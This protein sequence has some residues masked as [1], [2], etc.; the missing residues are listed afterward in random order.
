MSETMS[1][2]LVKTSILPTDVIS[3]VWFN[4]AEPKD[5]GSLRSELDKYS[6]RILRE[7]PNKPVG[8]FTGN[9]IISKM[10]AC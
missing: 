5:P 7:Q 1:W 3:S 10:V 4:E 8:N 2:S 9:I 6:E